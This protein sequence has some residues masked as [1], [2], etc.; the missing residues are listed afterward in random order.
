MLDDHSFCYFAMV[1]MALAAVPALGTA[2]GRLVY[3]TIYAAIMLNPVLLHLTSAEALEHSFPDSHFH[4]AF[5]PVVVAILMA[6]L[7]QVPAL[8]E[9]CICALPVCLQI[10]HASACGTAVAFHKAITLH[11]P[12][13]V[14]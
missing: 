3:G 6:P 4:E 11:D 8:S 10:S 14:Q 1:L 7:A 12:P 9:L 2:G 5:A 13:G